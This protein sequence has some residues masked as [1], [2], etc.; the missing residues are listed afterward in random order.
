MPPQ[1]PNVLLE[2]QLR[3][4][5][6]PLDDAALGIL[7]AHLSWVD[8]A[9]GQTLMTQG[10]PGDAM[11]LTLS[12]RLRTYLRD[13]DGVER[14]VR[15]LGRGQVVG[16]ISLYTDEPRSATVVAIRDS[17]LVRL[18]KVDFQRLLQVSSAASIALTRQIILRLQA[19]PGSVK[20]ARPVNIALIPVSAGVPVADFAPALAGQLQR[21]LPTGRVCLVDADC[22]DEALAQPGLARSALDDDVAGFALVVAHELP[23]ARAETE[24]AGG[25]VVLLHQFVTPFRLRNS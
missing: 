8:L 6:G 7:L 24:V 22:V 9:A 1:P 3:A 2:R 14:R 12:G 18:A 16:E 19:A 25:S 13:D 10:E 17:V 21:L 4:F 5:L 15:E 11:Y 23:F 20:E